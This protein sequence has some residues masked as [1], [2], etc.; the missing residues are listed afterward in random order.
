[1]CK[2]KKHPY[3]GG[4][5]LIINILRF[6][7][8]K[9]LCDSMEI[10][11]F[12]RST[13]AVSGFVLRTFSRSLARTSSIRLTIMYVTASTLNS[14]AKGIRTLKLNRVQRP[15]EIK[16]QF[17]VKPALLSP[18]IPPDHEKSLTPNRSVKSSF[19]FRTSSCATPPTTKFPWP[20]IIFSILKTCFVRTAATFSVW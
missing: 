2:T 18:F 4:I 14:V 3:R 1:M 12:T 7:M 13:R 16:H 20:K 6:K 17:S 15:T 19:T 8:Q 9:K 10:S 5:T 11:F